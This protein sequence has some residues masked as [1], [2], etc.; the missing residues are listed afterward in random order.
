MDPLDA[1]NVES[2]LTPRHETE[3]VLSGA[4][5]FLERVR[6]YAPDAIRPHIV[7]G[8]RCLEV[9]Y[10]GLAF[11]RWQPDGVFFG[12]GDR[13]QPLSPGREGRI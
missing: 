1:G 5:S 4:A 11:A 2:W 3:A 8:A 6:R 10:R 7:P 13:Q 12:I 9:R